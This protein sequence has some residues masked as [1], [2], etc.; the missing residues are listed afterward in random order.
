[1]KQS[2]HGKPYSDSENDFP[3]RETTFPSRDKHNPSR[4]NHDPGKGNDVPMAEK[5]LNLMESTKTTSFCQCNH[6]DPGLGVQIEVVL[7]QHAGKSGQRQLRLGDDGRARHS[8]R[9]VLVG[10]GY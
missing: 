7:F 6:G 2:A 4:E 3:S 8:V 1:L 10:R 5:P 9:A